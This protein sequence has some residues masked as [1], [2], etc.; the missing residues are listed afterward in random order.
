MNVLPVSVYVCL[1]T[2]CVC[3]SKLEEV[4]LNRNKSP[5]SSM[6]VSDRIIKDYG[7]P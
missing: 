6:A 1:V 2:V 7:K 5:D 3:T 4:Q